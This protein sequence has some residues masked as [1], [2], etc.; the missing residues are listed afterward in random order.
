MDSGGYLGMPILTIKHD[1]LNRYGKILT[2]NHESWTKICTISYITNSLLIDQYFSTRR[3]QRKR[4][5]TLA[6]RKPSCNTEKDNEFFL[7]L[8]PV[9]FSF[10]VSM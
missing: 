9:I 4:R 5:Q 6:L 8:L 7:S 2:A 1:N 10:W 3:R